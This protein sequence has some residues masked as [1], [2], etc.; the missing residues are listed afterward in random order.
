M[1]SEEMDETFV[2]NPSV[3]IWLDEHCARECWRFG[4][5]PHIVQRRN[6][7]HAINPVRH[8]EPYTSHEDLVPYIEFLDRGAATLFGLAYDTSVEEVA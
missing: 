3:A 8:P 6:V 2:M 1:K 4:W 7:A 5:E